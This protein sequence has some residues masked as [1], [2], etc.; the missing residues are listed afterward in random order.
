MKNFVQPGANITVV[1]VAAA[2]SGA[3]V[4]IGSLFGINSNDVEVGDNQVLVTEGVFTHPKAA[5]AVTVGA[6]IYWDPAA[7]LMT[8]VAAGG[9]LI[10]VAVAAAGAADADVQVKLGAVA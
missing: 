9:T 6:K 7:K 10:G 1:A 5:G 8:T 4:L 2:L 3:G